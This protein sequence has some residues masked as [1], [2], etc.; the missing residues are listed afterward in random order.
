MDE[1]LITRSDLIFD[2]LP[3][4]NIDKEKVK[5]TLS[6]LSSPIHLPC[7]FSIGEKFS[8]TILLNK[9]RSKYYDSLF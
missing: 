2:V 9:K 5:K 4:L 8:K 3:Y 1:K 6:M 7:V